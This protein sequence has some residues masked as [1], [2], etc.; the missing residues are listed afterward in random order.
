MSLLQEIEQRNREAHQQLLANSQE[1]ERQ[2]NAPTAQE[3]YINSRK[4]VSQ[5]MQQMP[6]TQ[7][8]EED[9]TPEEQDQYD[10]LEQQAIS[11][12]NEQYSSDSMLQAI[13]TSVDAVEGIG[14]AAFDIISHLK[15]K[16]P[17]I[18]GDIL[19][20]LGENIVGFITD[21]S[22]VA[23]P[24]LNLSED[25][26]AE[27]YSIALQQYMSAYPQEVDDDMRDYLAQEPPSQL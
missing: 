27:A 10:Q 9:A 11:I 16:T 14:N 6:D 19:Q 12:I 20:A 15:S 5:G 18:S 25:D 26:V 7:M 22:E 13:N 4:E 24:H 2:L 3:S 8:Q 21:L 17:D 23:N 1:A